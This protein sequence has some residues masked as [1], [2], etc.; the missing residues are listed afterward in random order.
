[1][2]FARNSILSLYKWPFPCFVFLLIVTTT[3]PAKQQIKSKTKCKA[4][5]KKALAK[6]APAKKAPAK[7]APAKTATAN[8]GDQERLQHAKKV[9]EAKKVFKIQM[10]LQ[11][12]KEDEEDAREHDLYVEEQERK[13]AAK[14]KRKMAFDAKLTALMDVMDKLLLLKWNIV[15]P[16]QPPPADLCMWKCR[17]MV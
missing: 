8:K 4:L 15:H 17:D 10:M 14:K 1:M 16:S 6:K 12:K 11:A 3:M 5:A 13:A 2:I 9:L 7:T